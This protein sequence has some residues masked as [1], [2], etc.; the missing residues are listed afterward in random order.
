MQKIALF[1]D[2]TNLRDMLNQLEECEVSYFATS[3]DLDRLPNNITLAVFDFDVVPLSLLDA[4]EQFP[5]LHLRKMAVVS[6]ENLDKVDAVL[7]RLD[8]YVVRPLSIQRITKA[9]SLMYERDLSSLLG[10]FS[11]EFSSPITSLR[12]YIDLLLLDM[13]PEDEIK[14]YFRIAKHNIEFIHEYIQKLK[15]WLKHEHGRYFVFQ[16]VQVEEIFDL[17]LTRLEISQEI[18]VFIPK[19]LPNVLVDQ[20]KVIFVIRVI[21]ANASI[22]SEPDTRIRLSCTTEHGFLVV[23]IADSG[24]GILE[25]EKTLIFAKFQRGIQPIAVSKGGWGLELY[26]CK[27]I[28]EMHGGRIWFESEVGVGTTFHFTFPLADETSS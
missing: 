3:L 26:L 14:K 28:I 5:R 12:G 8:N 24:I 23:A 11:T 13:I 9:M 10:F 4:W 16:A 7:E 22:F 18:D 25:K 21:L 19:D 2:D 27:Q 17:V 15:D 1:S 6:T 20:S